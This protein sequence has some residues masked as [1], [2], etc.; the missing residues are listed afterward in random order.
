VVC[1][2][3]TKKIDSVKKVPENINY[4]EF[5]VGHS[6]ILT[7]V[8]TYSVFSPL[9][10]PA[11]IL[12]FLLMYFIDKH[13]IL[14]VAQSKYPFFGKMWLVTFDHLLTAIIMSD[15]IYLSFFIGVE[16]FP[17]FVCAG[18]SI[19]IAGLFWWRMDKCWS[20]IGL[21]GTLSDISDAPEISSDTFTFQYTHP[22]FLPVAP[23]DR[24]YV[25]E[26]QLLWR[27]RGSTLADVSLHSF[28]A[29]DKKVSAEKSETYELPE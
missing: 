21:L 4:G 19:L 9:I 12:Y 3:V 18:I 26:E 15:I 6:F 25:S 8:L 27:Q 5:S 29:K 23:E 11:G 22:L 13:F 24:E 2:W 7:L 10:I 20:C 17:G 14:Y 1:S 28:L 16:F